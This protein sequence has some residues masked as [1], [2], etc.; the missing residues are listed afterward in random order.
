MKFR[1]R[2]RALEERLGIARGLKPPHLILESVAREKDSDGAQT[3]AWIEPRFA[4][5]D[6]CTGPIIERGP[7]ESLEDFKTRVENLPRKRKEPG[8]ATITSFFTKHPDPPAE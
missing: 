4:R 5:L 1:A 6:D 8:A 7:N 3:G 2:L